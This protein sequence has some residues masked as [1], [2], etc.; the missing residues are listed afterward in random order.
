[1]NHMKP[2]VQRTAIA[3]AIA[4]A[5]VSAAFFIVVPRAFAQTQ[6]SCSTE[7]AARKSEAQGWLAAYS[8][9][10]IA[11]NEL[12]KAVAR[13]AH[14][15]SG[16]VWEHV[17]PGIA[18]GPNIP[19]SLDGVEILRADLYYGHA[20]A[21]AAREACR[22]LNCDSYTL[23]TTHASAQAALTAYQQAIEALPRFSGSAGM[24]GTGTQRIMNMHDAAALEQL[25]ANGSCEND[26]ARSDS[27]ASDQGA[28]LIAG[29][30]RCETPA[31]ALRQGNRGENV[32]R[33]Q[34]FLVS[35]G[36][37]TSENATGFFGRLTERAVQNF[38]TERGIV[39]S[40][41]PNTSGYGRV[42]GRTLAAIRSMCGN[43]PAT[44]PRAEAAEANARNGE[45]RRQFSN[46]IHAEGEPGSGDY[47]SGLT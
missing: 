26:G 37:M 13:A 28:A 16:F 27:S 22:A 5:I 14:A 20:Q 31:A 32:R 19:D 1:M 39:T 3:G 33:L 41:T 25:A 44:V 8:R 17:S 34:N 21:E 46:G 2:V 35:R 47:G 9:S 15:P 23:P 38:Q 11:Y 36:L 30:G 4:V 12:Y 29:I 18:Q 40:G 7:A 42:G 43:A 10:E 6:N 45:Q 24:R